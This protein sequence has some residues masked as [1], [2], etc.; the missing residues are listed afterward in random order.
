MRAGLMGE[1]VLS[2]PPLPHLSPCGAPGRGFERTGLALL[3]RPPPVLAVGMGVHGR[4]MARLGGR[5]KRERVFFFFFFPPPPPPPANAR[6]C[7]FLARP[8]PP[9]NASNP[10]ASAHPSEPSL[11][12][13]PTHRWAPTPSPWRCRRRQRRRRPARPR[14]PGRPLGKERV[15]SFRH[16]RALG[17]V[18]TQ[19]WAGEAPFHCPWKERERG[20]PVPR[21]VDIEKHKRRV[22]AFGR[23]KKIC[24][25]SRPLTHTHFRTASKT[26]AGQTHASTCTPFPTQSIAF[27]RV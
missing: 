6:R 25:V 8:P 18:C 9:R 19:G 21:R 17:A 1:W 14:P 2:P 20:V 15:V 3:A 16:T 13:C 4:S 22:G 24:L 10:T 12:T 5:A 26:E 23:E 7:S 11:L 27:W